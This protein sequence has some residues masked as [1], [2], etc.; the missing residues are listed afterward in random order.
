MLL[1]PGVT[2]PAVKFTCERVIGKN[3]Q[4][5][6]MVLWRKETGALKGNGAGS[7][8]LGED[9]PAVSAIRA[10]KA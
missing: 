6:L 8:P 10:G 5:A 3:K 9:L 7:V 1:D 2:V 4:S